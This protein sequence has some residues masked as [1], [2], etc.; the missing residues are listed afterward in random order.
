MSDLIL[1]DDLSGLLE[2]AATF[3]K[4]PRPVC[5]V[6]GLRGASEARTEDVL[7]IS[8]ETRNS[9]P[10]IAGAAVSEV[11][12]FAAGCGRQLIFKKIDS[13]LRGPVRAE[14][15]ALSRFFPHARILFAP[16]NPAAGRTVRQGQLC[17]RGVPVADTE[18][19]RDPVSPV[20]SSSLA[21]FVEPSMARSV[22]IPDVETQRDFD[23]I[24]REMDESGKP[25]IGVGSGGLAR[26]IAARRAQE[27]HPTLDNV[28]NSL[29]S[30]AVLLVCGSAH[31]LNRAQAEEL[32]NERGV[33][34]IEVPIGAS[35]NESDALAGDLLSG[36]PISALLQ[37]QRGDSGAASKTIVAM[38]AQLIRRANV[39]R[40]FITGGETAYALC[41]ALDVTA[42]RPVTE[43]EPG[44]TLSTANSPTGPLLL[45]IK[46][47][48]FGDAR[49]WIRAFDRLRA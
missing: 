49:T 35:V 46:P 27:D 14:L 40:L 8:T 15:A 10:A 38:A 26:A 5:S 9:P 6:L 24:V 17:V 18:F 39:R 41:C 48:G 20:R 11:L 4:R 23:V 7:A 33:R 28:S 47:G 43:L 3:H 34:L 25:W 30:S 29:T 19:G 37:P 45:A 36:K 21:E 31:E 1:A 22:I 42:L 2:V 16:A 13:T 44:V 32:R 12:A